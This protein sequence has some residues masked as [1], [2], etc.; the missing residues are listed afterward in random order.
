MTPPI[1][2]FFEYAGPHMQ[3]LPKWALANRKLLKPL[4]FKFF[5]NSKSGAA[6]LRTTQVPTI[7]SSGMRD[8]V[9][10]NR[11]VVTY[12]FR[13]LP[14]YD[15]ER[16]IQHLQKII[17][18][19]TVKISPIEGTPYEKGSAVSPH[20]H[21]AFE[22]LTASLKASFEEVVVAPYLV[23]AA[24]DSRHFAAVSTQVYRF[25]PFKLVSDDLQRIHGIN[26]R[27]AV[28]AYLQGIQFYSQAMHDFCK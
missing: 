19:T 26:E 17:N 1:E 14:G 15:A 12:N 2:G 24:T 13:L 16:V 3:A 4:I 27:I 28:E 25:T 10:P 22:K 23:L 7:I 8:N 18:D 11:G 9:V 5:G 21:E 20:N 6:L